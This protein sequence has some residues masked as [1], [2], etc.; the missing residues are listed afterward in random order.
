MSLDRPD[1]SPH[2]VHLTRD[3]ENTNARE[4][5]ISILNDA[6]IEARNPYGIAVRHL[7]GT[8]CDAPEFMKSQKVACFS[9]TP[10]DYLPTLI[11]PGIWRRY[12]FQPYGLVFSRDYMI[13][14]GANEV[15]Y[16]NTFPSS[17][18]FRWLAH[19]INELIDLGS[20]DGEK[21]PDA[22]NW[23]A[24]WIARVTPYIETVGKWQTGYM[25]ATR[26]KD[27]TFEREWRYSGD[28]HFARS[29]IEAIIVPVGEAE[30]FA[31][32]LTERLGDVAG[33]LLRR[34]DFVEMRP[35]QVETTV[36]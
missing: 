12:K 28:F 6:C 1:L 27:F 36:S 7:E 32:E 4:N 21:R 33:L 31:D 23:D 24:S 25:G 17:S 35:P 19:D 8:G 16:L 13:Y 10:L 34:A 9:A 29:K 15:W 22:K 2:I 11:E 26:A 30:S 14:M 18:A 5:L 3:Y 20:L